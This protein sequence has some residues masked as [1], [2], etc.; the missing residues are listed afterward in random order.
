[1]DI[2]QSPLYKKYITAL[3]WTV[4]CLDGTNIWIKKI[5]IL[6]TLAKIQRPEILPYLPKL[7]PL[8]KRHHVRTVAAES[9]LNQSQEEFMTWING[10]SKFFRI[11][12]ETYLQTKTILIDLTKPEGEIFKAFTEAK[13]RAVRRA[14]KHGVII[15]E[16]N[17]IRDLM[18]IKNISAGML[19]SMTTYGIDI[20]WN[21]F[22]PKHAT[23]LLA[24]NPVIPHL[25]VIPAKAGI[26]KMPDQ[27][28][29][30]NIIGGILLLFWENIAYYW[31]AG[32][33]K[34][35]KKLFAPTLLVWEALKLSKKR[36]CKQFDFVGVLD[37]RLPNKFKSWK[38][39][40]KF[41]E[42]FGGKK[43]YYPINY[44][45]SKTSR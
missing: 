40:T 45:Y 32:A 35:G 9:S 43:V 3:R 33:T 10:L 12:K 16:S 24:Y 1:M 6:G 11:S 41:K 2:Q 44:S 42:G 25:P 23:I 29:H 31:I 37:E 39:F 34:K 18:Y 5:P 27:V 17:N 20:L 21:I 26:L 38:G 28:R 15:K 4:L 13:Q 22:Y 30:D 8:L 19:G 7:I 14:Q 36:R